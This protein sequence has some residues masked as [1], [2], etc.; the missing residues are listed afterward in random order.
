VERKRLLVYALQL[1]RERGSGL[2]LAAVLV[3]SSQTNGHMGLPEEGIQ[4]AEEALGILE[5]L[6]WTAGQA[7]CLIG[8]ASSLLS[9]GQLH[10]A[11]EAASRAINLLPENG[12]QFLVCESHKALGRMCKS[13]GEIEKAIRHYGL[14]LGIAS[15]FGWHDELFWLHYEMAMIFRDEGRL[16]DVQAHIEHAKSHTANS[17]YN[18]GHVMEGQARIW[19]EQHRLEEARAEALHAADIYEK[20]GVVEGVEECRQILRDIEELNAPVASGQSGFDCELL[21]MPLPACIDCS[22]QAQ[23]AE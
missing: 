9:N 18:L 23:E 12:Q 21:V 7:Y 10:A 4:Q 1:Q 2:P 17:T 5:R 11:E 19:Y 6:G 20:L 14:A 22:F 16:D 13:K 15:S 8:L 3:E